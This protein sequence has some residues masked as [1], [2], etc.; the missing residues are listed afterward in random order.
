M[1]HI[2]RLFLVTNSTYFAIRVLLRS[3]SLD[4]KVGDCS[5]NRTG[6]PQCGWG[7]AFGPLTSLMRFGQDTFNNV[8]VLTIKYFGLLQLFV[9]AQ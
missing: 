8:L 6:V 2:F 4:N 7:A 9:Q 5:L 3:S 1:V